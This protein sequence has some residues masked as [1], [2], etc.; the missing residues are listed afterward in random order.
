MP[1]TN[2]TLPS[3]PLSD[4]ERLREQV[5]NP[6]ETVIVEAPASPSEPA[7]VIGRVSQDKPY[8]LTES[9]R[10]RIMETLKRGPQHA[11]PDEEKHQ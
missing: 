11:S 9:E 6:R 1:R 2:G 7:H 4:R 5:R 10:Q 8:E 3:P